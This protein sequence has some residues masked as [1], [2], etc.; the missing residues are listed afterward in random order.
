MFSSGHFVRRDLSSRLPFGVVF[1]LLGIQG[2]FVL[3]ESKSSVR[4]V[5]FALKLPDDPLWYRIDDRRTS[6]RTRTVS[7]QYKRASPAGTSLHS[8]ARPPQSLV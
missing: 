4:D 7:N 5:L 2:G 1:P 3:V 8:Q 6:T